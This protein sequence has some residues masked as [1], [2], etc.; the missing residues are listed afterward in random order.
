MLLELKSLTVHMSTTKT[1]VKWHDQRD[2]LTH[3]FTNRRCVGIE[4]SSKDERRCQ[5][6]PDMHVF[7]AEAR[8]LHCKSGSLCSFMLAP[9]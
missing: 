4:Q 5:A 1:P 8:L 9:H 2:P 3:A 7:P 6:C